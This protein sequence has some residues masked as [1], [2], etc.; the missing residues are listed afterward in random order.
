MKATTIGTKG[1]MTMKTIRQNL[2]D[3]PRSWKWVWPVAILGL[4][5]VSV[6]N[7]QAADL[8]HNSADT[9]STKW[10]AQGGWGVT[11]GK[12]GKFECATCHEPDAENLKNI[13][14]TITT[15]NGEKWPNGASSVNVTF[16]NSTSMGYDPG[17]HA[18]S[19]RICEVCHSANQFHNFNTANNTGGVSH[20]TPKANCTSC[21][22]HNTGFKAACGGCHGNPPTSAVL[23]GDYGLIGTPRP[24]NALAAGQYGAHYTHTQTRDMICDTCHYI[25]NGTVKMPNLSNTIDIGFFGFGGKVTSGTYVP[26]SSTNRGFR[27]ASGTPNTTIASVVTTYAAANKCANV[28]CHGGGVKVGSTQVKAPLTGGSNVT[29]QWTATSQNQ[30]G[31]CHGVSSA[32]P[33]TMGS[34]VKHVVPVWSAQSGN[35]DLCHPAIDM[36]HVQGSLRWEMKLTDPRVGANAAYKGQAKGATGDMAPSDSYGQCTNV[37]CH[38]D[39]K[40]NPPRINATWGSPTFNADCA[41]CHGGNAD[42][43][44]PITT[45]MHREHINQI[46]VNG[47]NFGCVECH[48]QTVTADRSIG[49]LS[50]HLN[51]LVNYS[52]AKAGK[53]KNACNNAYCHTNGKG[54]AGMSVNWAGGTPINNCN[55]CHGAASPAD[56]TANYGEP[57]YVT[58]GAGVPGANSHKKHVAA[59]TG[60]CV[61]CHAGTVNANG[62]LTGTNHLN[63]S[64]QVAPGGGENF[65]YPGG[66]SCSAITCHGAGAPAATWGAI[67]PVECTG[68]HGGNAAIAPSDIK[69]GKHTQH[70]NN[71]AI[72]GANLGCVECHAQTVDSDR[73]IKNAALHPNKLVNYSGAKAGRNAATC[74]TA[75]CHTDGKG[76]AGVVVSWTSGPAI[77]KCIGCHGAASPADFVSIYGEPNYLSSLGDRANSH[78]KHVGTSGASTC[79]YCHA[80]TVAG[81]G[82]LFGTQ[83]LNTKIDVSPGGGKGFTYPGGKTCS[84]ISCHGAGSPDAVWGATMP[85]DCT[86]CHGGNKDAVPNDIKTGSH[87]QHI[88]QASLNGVNYGCVECHAQTVNGDRSVINQGNHGN[89][90]ANYSGARAGKNS[91]ACN[92]SYC[93]SD[94]KGG[95]GMVVSW[96]G[97]TPIN[98]CIGCHGMASPADFASIAGEPNYANE[99]PDKIRAN[100]HLSHTKKLSLTGAASCQICHIETVATAGTTLLGNANHLNSNFNVKFNTNFAGLTADYNYTTK[101]CNTIS[102]H[103]GGSPR[104]GDAASAGC[105]ACHPNPGGAHAAHIGNLLSAGMVS[106]YNFTANRSIGTFY[107]FG[108]ANCHPATDAG[109]HRN[110]TVEIIMRKDKSGANKLVSL[111]NLIT[112]DM[113]G[114]TKTASDNFTCETVYCHSNGRTVGTAEAMKLEDYRRTP[115]WYGLPYTG[116]KC[117]MCH[118]NPPSY[119]GQ[120]HY[121]AESSLGDNGVRPFAE[122]GHMTGIHYMNTYVGNNKNGYLGY[123]SS[124]NKAHGNSA[125]ATT[126]SCYI[127]H[128]GI[129]SSTKIDTYAMY[130]TSSE[131]R[132]ATCHKATSRTPL[133]AGEITDTSRHINGTK[134]VEFAPITIKTKAQL[135]VAANALSWSRN[136]GYK[137]DSSFDSADLRVATWN[138]QN[139]SCLTACHVNQLNITWGGQ[140][141]CVSCHANQ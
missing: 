121:V 132:C 120:S 8:L 113:G 39:G 71:A 103:G 94:G 61:Y 73:S 97:G 23:G 33:P 125:L 69:T 79:V 50:N 137:A 70:I 109:T 72:N 116:N 140:L 59:G 28:Y 96:T 44:A 86:G 108:C 74:N 90:L 60:S 114:F 139:K 38:T 58:A 127:C 29:P 43:A 141:K 31:S 126:I 12:Y 122:T 107:R 81:D 36:S 110:G 117:A 84:N 9:A 40:G 1:E 123:S 13:R 115:N 128:S 5:L 82:K 20:P 27:I 99:G 56:F 48:A 16:L 76:A 53:N 15:P 7:A 136:N 30:C 63:R 101:T 98:N 100:S 4:L 80:G 24:S 105:N 133:Q 138:P 119:A 52:G 134:D 92:A 129:V 67:F 89:L 91:A 75:Y 37:L 104:W 106:F 19:S 10:Q 57:N 42:S 66:K 22:K 130:N 65:G 83:H 47:V 6:I 85:I 35:C 18:T 17:G 21:H 111:N 102:C 78:K 14:K 51:Q 49:T 11:G 46:S 41:G 2:N 87:T 131:F 95:V 118:D 55:G 45:D 34:H 112:T 3:D 93:H 32:S 88:N 64:I 25:S 135:S 77:D 62:T 26:Y 54:V 68:C 124:G